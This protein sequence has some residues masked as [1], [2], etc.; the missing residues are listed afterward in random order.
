MDHFDFNR[1]V[2]SVAMSYLDRYLS[3]RRVNKKIFQLAAMTCLYLAIKL[4]EPSTLK[5]ASLIGL[6]RGFFTTEHIVAMEQS[7]LR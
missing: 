1:E 2:V 6:S 4:S 7:I 5:I 3:T